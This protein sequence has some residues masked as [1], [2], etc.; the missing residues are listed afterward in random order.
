MSTR[1]MQHSD[2]KYENEPANSTDNRHNPNVSTATRVAEQ[3]EFV[4][5][6]I[7]FK[8]LFFSP[9]LDFT[10]SCILF[11]HGKHLTDTEEDKQMRRAPNVANKDTKLIYYCNLMFYASFYHVAVRVK[12][13]IALLTLCDEHHIFAFLIPISICDFSMQHSFYAIFC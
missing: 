9:S 11:M 5:L 7:S 13:L 3:N 1:K 12:R 8:P 2:C 10:N 4:L 6:Q